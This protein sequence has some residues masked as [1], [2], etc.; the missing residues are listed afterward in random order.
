MIRVII[1]REI[2]E[3]LERFYEQAIS[4]LLDVMA[5]APGYLAGESLVEIH[6]PNRYL[7]VTRWASEEAWNRWF[8][9]PERQE[10]LDSV[11]PFLQ[12][13][14]K[15]TLLRQLKYHRDDSA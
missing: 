11:R 1:E 7:V 5:N 8:V 12:N 14:E 3:G 9:S 2:A 15:L 6:R 13:D 4:N 10:L